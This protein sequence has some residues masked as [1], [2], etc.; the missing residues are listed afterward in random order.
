[1]FA[2]EILCLNGDGSS[3]SSSQVELGEQHMNQTPNMPYNG[4]SCCFKTHLV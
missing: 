3:G 2:K 4:D 1:M